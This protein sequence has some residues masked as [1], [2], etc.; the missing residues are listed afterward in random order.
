MILLKAD[1]GSFLKVH[2]DVIGCFVFEDKVLFKKHMTRLK[3]DLP[4]VSSALDSGVFDGKHQETLTLFPS[5]LKKTKVMLIGLGKSELLTLERMRRCAATAARTSNGLKAQ[6]LALM[7]PEDKGL[8]A[9]GLEKDWERIAN[10]LGEG[11]VLSLYKYNAY[12]TGKDKNKTSVKQISIVSEHANRAREI[13]RGVALT[14]IV[15]EATILARD[16]T[17]APPNEIYPE[18]LAR[19]AK[20]TGRKSGFAVKVSDEK[21]IGRLK[22]GGVLAVAKGS[23]RPPRFIVME[24][25]RGKRSLPTIV[26]VGKG[27]T[28]DAG[29]ISIKPAAG[30]GEMKMDMA[31]AAAVIATMQAVARLKLPLHVVGL[32]PSV[33]NLLGGKAMKPGDI[34]THLNGKTSE[35]DNTD[36]EGRLILADALSYADRFKPDAA[37]DL[38]TL[39]GHVVVGL[40][41]YATGMMGNDD[42]TMEKLRKAGERTYERVWQLPMFDEY[43]KQIKSDVANVKNSGGRPAGA[44]TAALFLKQFIGNYKWV[45]LDIAGTATLSESLEYIPK[46]ASGVGVRLLVDVL[47]DWNKQSE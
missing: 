29:G 23:D 24:H 42:A 46:G 40:G 43:E 26:L 37:I 34:V 22:M 12:L 1:R 9:S 39:T 21:E 14:Q 30:M 36:A 32:V 16:L 33:E 45:H 35:V 13:R 41:H 11:A 44:I 25:N 8:S 4:S 31:G 7:L 17:N 3:N 6:S 38:A 10:A 19:K 27:V 2:A 47:R 15:C 28:F 5:E 18:T 20:D